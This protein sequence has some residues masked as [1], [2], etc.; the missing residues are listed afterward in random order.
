M[1]GDK[2]CRLSVQRGRV[3]DIPCVLTAQIRLSVWRFGDELGVVSTWLGLAR[4]YSA[5]TGHV[6]R[7]QCKNA[8]WV[9]LTQWA[10]VRRGA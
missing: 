7:H 10:F 8:H 2:P 9:T 3:G 5:C 6:H 4:H 1:L